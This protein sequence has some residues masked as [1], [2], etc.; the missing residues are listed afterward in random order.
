MKSKKIL[1]VLIST[2]VILFLA[3]MYIFIWGKLFICSPIIVGFNRHEFKKVIVYI[4][5]GNNFEWPQEIDRYIDKV[6]EF[7]VLEFK[8][9]PKIFFF[10]DRRTYARRSVSKARF[11]TFYNGNIV[12]SPWAQEEAMNGII[13]MEIYLRHEL[14]HSLLFQHKGLLSA[15]KYPKWL[16]E[17][18]AVY[19]ANQMGTFV[20]PSKDE[21]YRLMREREFLPPQYFGTK[22]EDEITLEL[23][24]KMA[25]VYAE[26][27]CIVDYLIR[28]YG[29]ER[30]IKYMKQLLTED[31]HDLVFKNIF[32]MDFLEFIS[33]FRESVAK[34]LQSL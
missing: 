19:S 11:N 17:G 7:H 15:Y 2:G 1:I 31:N 4:Q 26:F 25:F 28:N 18:I 3:V 23:D 34:P 10:S 21:T 22:K 12:V 20:Y 6:E 33:T 5:K 30:F 16:L 27:A 8:K 9:K 14:S 32:G 29:K 24:N 13:S